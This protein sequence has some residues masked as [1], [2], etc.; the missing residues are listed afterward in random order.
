MV[1]NKSQCQEISLVNEKYSIDFK[2]LMIENSEIK[3]RVREPR[4]VF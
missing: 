4:R 1:V 2:C 3:E